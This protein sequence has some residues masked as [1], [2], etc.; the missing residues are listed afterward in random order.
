MRK[1]ALALAASVAALT[2]IGLPA[3]ARYAPREFAR[4]VQWIYDLERAAPTYV[5]AKRIEVRSDPEPDGLITM[6]LHRGQTLEVAGR[7]QD[8]WVAVAEN[9]VIRGYVSE[10]VV[11]AVA[12]D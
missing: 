6:I 11:G 1:H 2:V 5:A 3:Q 4:G 7:T 8:G 9:G 12:G 10:G